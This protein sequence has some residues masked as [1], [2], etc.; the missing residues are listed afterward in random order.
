MS[1][2]ENAIYTTVSS[3]CQSTLQMCPELKWQEVDHS[4]TTGALLGPQLTVLG[5]SYGTRQHSQMEQTLIKGKM[6]K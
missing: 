5:S 4:W 6:T 1:L 3:M 2:Y